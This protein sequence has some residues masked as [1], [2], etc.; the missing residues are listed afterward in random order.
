[1]RQARLTSVVAIICSLALVGVPSSAEEGNKDHDHHKEHKH[2]NVKYEATIHDHATG[3]IL[4]REFD[5]AESEDR[6][7]F[8]KLLNVGAIHE[9]ELV[10]EVNI[11]AIAYDLGLWTLV[12]FLLLLLVLSRFAWKPMLEGL[13]KREQTILEAVE[14][15]KIARKE[16]AEERAKFKAE[17]DDAYAKI[18]KMMEEARKDAENLKQEMRSQAQAEIQ[19]ER[20]RLRR[21]IDTARDQ[22]LQEIWNQSVNLATMISQKAIRRSM[23]EEDHRRLL[24]ESLAELQEAN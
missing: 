15:A 24:D 4:T 18:P 12:V 2:G 20:E 5:L 16:Q 9:A 14:E 11:L 13:Q 19:T 22:A 23:S 7:E 17:M 21:E 6:D 10:Q 1:M 3:D 8:V